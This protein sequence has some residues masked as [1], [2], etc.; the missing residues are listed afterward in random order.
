MSRATPQQLKADQ[1]GQYRLSYTVTDNKGH[2]I[3]GGYVF[4][5]RGQGFDGR[6]FRFNDVELITDKKEYQAGDSVHLMINTQKADS[7]LLL[8]IRPANGIYLPPKVIRMK[9]KSA[10]KTS[11][12]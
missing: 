8:F 5:V 1:P 11:A 10:W 2:A 7:T 6:D 3:E 4:V 9:G 12:W